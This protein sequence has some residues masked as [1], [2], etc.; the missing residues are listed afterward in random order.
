MYDVITFGSATWDIFLDLEKPHFIKSKKFITNK[1]ICFNLGSKRDVSD[2][3]FASGGGGTNTAVSFKKQGLKVA[4][5]G[6]VGDDISGNEVI[7]RLEKSGVD[8]SLVF[9]N[10]LKPTNH[11]VILDSGSN[12]DRTILAYRGASEVLDRKD[13]PWSKLKAR[14]FYLAPLSGKLANITKDIVDFAKIN[15]IKVAFNPS[16]SQLILKDLRK[17]VDKVDVLLI[18]QE[19]ASVLT[20][21]PF[22]KE[23][24]I[25]KTIDKMCPGITIM[26][27]GSDGVVVSDGN[28]LYR[29]KP[30]KIKIVDRTGAG[31]SFGSGFVSGLI[32]FENN[33][34]EAIQLG[35]ANANSCL[36]KQGAKNGLLGKEAKFK[37]AK[38][39]K[40]KL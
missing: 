34:E 21:I 23:I 32:R 15:G 1:G 2:I 40:N 27:K 33:I 14:W 9:K 16:N 8:C 39:T 29:A 6:A 10:K 31:D 20:E 22:K 3:G 38:V 30:G 7:N 17:I 4:Y 37:K 28:Y 11:S 19:E 26:T 24:K 25:F 12:K 5:C 13:I 36:Q 18:N 35:I